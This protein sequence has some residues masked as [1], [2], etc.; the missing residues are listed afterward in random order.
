MMRPLMKT[1]RGFLLDADNTLFDYD[2]GEAEALEEACR[3]AIPGVPFARAQA[4]YR[5]INAGY[6]KRLEEGSVG[7][8]AL[9]VGRFADLL[10]ELHAPGDP[11]AVSD[12]YLASLSARAYSLPHAEETV[13]E[14]ARGARLCLVT[15]G[16]SAVQ[17]GRIA[18]SGLEGCFT[19][20]LISEEAGCAKPDPRFFKAAVDALR[21]APADV[22]C[23]GDNPV[24]DIT[25][26]MN[27]GIDA[28]WYARAGAVWPGPGSPPPHIIH[29]L[30]E[31]III[32]GGVYP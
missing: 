17:R 8:E 7:F 6:W 15:N 25:G 10:A 26:A 18:A 12:A 32:A 22:L 20:L 2:R 27:A 9:K 21:L 5:R 3:A 13:R 28:C 1:Y 23:V 11:R 16:L 14:L 31:L 19:A 24:A 29:D 30:A 4:A